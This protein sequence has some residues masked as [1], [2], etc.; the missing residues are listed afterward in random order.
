MSNVLSL[1]ILISLHIDNKLLWKVGSTFLLSRKRHLIFSDLHINAASIPC[2]MYGRLQMLNHLLSVLGMKLWS[3]ENKLPRGLE[4]RP[5]SF[6]T[7]NTVGPGLTL[8]NQFAL[9]VS[10]SA[11]VESRAVTG[12]TRSF[13]RR[14]WF[15]RGSRFAK[16]C[17]ALEGTLRQ[18]NNGTSDKSGGLGGLCGLGRKYSCHCFIFCKLD[19]ASTIGIKSDESLFFSSSETMLLF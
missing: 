12:S 10:P 15:I 5:L 1:A 6:Q 7:S 11:F 16:S 3:G 4:A 19:L 14:R 17:A 8:K 13:P 9:A 2:M 18:G